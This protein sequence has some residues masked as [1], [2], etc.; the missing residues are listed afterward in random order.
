[1]KHFVGQQ[2]D[3]EQYSKNLLATNEGNEAM[4][5]CKYTELIL[6]QDRPVDS[7]HVEV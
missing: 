7:E 4:E 3:L 2:T 1:M 5:H 6:S